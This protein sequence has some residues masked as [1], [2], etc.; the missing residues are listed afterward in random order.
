MLER[1]RH[2]N[3]LEILAV[4]FG[5]LSF[6]TEL[7][8]KHV[9]VKSDNTTTVCYINSM[10]GTK[11]T[12]CNSLTKSIWLMCIE[13]DIWLT[14][15]YLPGKLNIDAD[16]NSRHFND[17][18]EWHLKPEVFSKV[19]QLLGKPDIDMFASRLNCQLNKYVSWKPDPGAVHIDA[20]TMCWNNMY[21]YLFPP[22]CLISR[23]LQKLQ[24]D[25]SVAL[26]IAPI[27]PTQFWWPQLLNLLVAQPIVLPRHQDLL[28]MPHSGEH[29]P[30]K[31][32]L[33]MMACLLSSDTSRQMEYQSKLLTCSCSHGE[34]P[35]RSNMLATSTSG[36]HFALNDRLISS[37]QL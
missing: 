35:Q 22:F 6:T 28:T 32:R 25:Q 18:T 27:W 34:D 12:E 4:H 5:L 19:S 30:L 13:N 31:N 26:M 1:D 33:K 16:H 23:C 8:G 37:A 15:C 14:A 10:G 21:I 2:I 11:S 9:C 20:F 7:K 24:E 36:L 29:H 3:E 17:K